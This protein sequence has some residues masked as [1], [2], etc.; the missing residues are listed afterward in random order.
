MKNLIKILIEKLTG[1]TEENTNPKK[2][3]KEVIEEVLAEEMKSIC[4]NEACACRDCPIKNTCLAEK[5]YKNNNCLINYIILCT[6]KRE[7]LGEYKNDA[8]K[9]NTDG[10]NIPQVLGELDLIPKELS[11]E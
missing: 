7:L 11:T 6:R 2:V 3:P 9:E 5:W 1:E 8:K 10:G 4:P